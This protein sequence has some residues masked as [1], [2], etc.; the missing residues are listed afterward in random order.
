MKYIIVDT[1]NVQV[2]QPDW[3]ACYNKFLPEI[4][5]IP[6]VLSGSASIDDAKNWLE[7]ISKTHPYKVVSTCIKQVKG[8]GAREIRALVAHNDG[9]YYPA[10]SA[11]EIY[12]SKQLKAFPANF[13]LAKNE[14]PFLIKAVRQV[15]EQ[16]N[17]VIRESDNENKMLH[18]KD[19]LWLKSKPS[20]Y[21][22]VNNNDVIIDIHINR[23]KDI[24][25]SD[26]LRLHYHNLVAS[27][28]GLKPSSLF[29]VNL[30]IENSLKEK[31]VSMANISPHAEKAAI[32]IVKEAIINKAP[33]VE[34][35]TRMIQQNQN[36]Y[37]KLAVVGQSHWDDIQSGVV[38]QKT[39]DFT[40][41]P[42]ELNDE[43]TNLSKTIVVS[44]YLKE[45]AAELE[46]QARVNMQDF[47][48]IN[49]IKENMNLPYE[50][51]TLR[52]NKKYDLNELF[53]VLTNKF[54]FPPTSLKNVSID[55]DTHMHLLDQARKTNLPITADQLA[56]ATKYEGLN[57]AAI[58]TAAN[59]VGLDLN[60]YADVSMVVYFSGQKRGPVFDAMQEIKN[61]IGQTTIHTINKLIESP[62]LD[63]QRLKENLKDSGISHAQ[64]F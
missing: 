42:A 41:M 52:K 22:R 2:K 28:V 36:T 59:E 43:Y 12:Q 60:D 61:E 7:C 18:G 30:Q 57:E 53:S 45:K 37:E 19:D 48:A 55:V 32:D 31:L 5:S 9:E 4:N 23:G 14:E 63:N 6:A 34:F 26:E 64:E 51:T 58:K 49:D 35:S 27:S 1:E 20:M 16:E 15:L 17:G 38:L 62:T 39:K 11:N 3:Q 40:T 25:H 56:T 29:Q 54:N 10:L 24:T 13:S 33:G 21:G 47:A 8:L 46:S 44:R 50:A